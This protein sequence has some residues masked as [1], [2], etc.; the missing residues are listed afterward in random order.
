[1]ISASFLI[2]FGIIQY[3]F[4]IDFGICF[5]PHPA[6][7]RAF[8]DHVA[9]QAGSAGSGGA[10]PLLTRPPAPKSIPGR[11]RVDP[12]LIPGSFQNGTLFSH[13]FPDLFFPVFFRFWTDFGSHFGSI[14][15]AFFVIFA[16]LF[17]ASILC[18]FLMGWDVMETISGGFG[19]DLELRFSHF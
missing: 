4:G 2:H 19:I 9:S 18:R 17:W 3:F 5:P 10:K 14:F 11:P 1:M 15:D 6:E 8:S 13:H 12:R 16:Y 7:C